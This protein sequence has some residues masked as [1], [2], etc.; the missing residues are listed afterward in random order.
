MA[1]GMAAFSSTLPTLRS[2]TPAGRKRVDVLVLRRNRCQNHV[3]DCLGYV[4]FTNQPQ[5]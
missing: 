4:E 2:L 3:L 5:S 1:G